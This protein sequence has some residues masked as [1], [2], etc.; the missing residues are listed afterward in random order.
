MTLTDTQR[1][2][3]AADLLFAAWGHPDRPVA[4]LPD[5]L[6]PANEA[7]AY[8]IQQALSPRLG[9]IGGWKVG[10]AGPD[11]PCTCAP[12][13]VDGFHRA[14]ARLPATTWRGRGVEAEVAVRLGHSLTP[15][16]APYTRAEVLAAIDTC[17][18]AIE[19]VQSRF[20]DPAHQ[21]RL[22]MLADFSAHGCFV[23]GPEAPGWR[24]V[25][26]AAEAVR[27]S[28]QG[29]HAAGRTAN[30][31]GDMVR[32]IQFL[33]DE[34]AVWAGGLLAGQFITTGSWT[35][36]TFPEIGETVRAEFDHL[37]AAELVFTPPA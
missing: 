5:E 4:A 2:A 3:Q 18:P 17:H 14:P 8:A 26:L 1:V 34:G 6:R 29:R 27:L 35:G 19:V 33:A 9:A 11:A 13:P 16:A 28:F 12:M 30:P 22:S 36:L 37:G 31:G 20:A 21:D 25:D 24:E 23:Y 32:L 15:R 10:A 7:Q